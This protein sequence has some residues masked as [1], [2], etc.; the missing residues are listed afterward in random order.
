MRSRKIWAIVFLAFIVRFVNVSNYPAGFTADEANQ[1]YSAYSILM[2][3]RDEW[4]EPFPITPRSFGDYKAPL[5]TYLTIPSV[6]VF[7]LSEFAVRFPAVIL[8]TLTVPVVYFLCLELFKDKKIAVLSSFLLAISPW[9]IALSR[10]AFEANLPTLLTPLGVLFFLKAKKQK[11]YMLAAALS[12]GLGLFS[13]HS[14]RLLF[15]LIMAFLYLFFKPAIAKYKMPLFLL[16]FF[17]SVALY[18]MFAGASSRIA[19]VSILGESSWKAVSEARYHAVVMG[20]PDFVARIFNNKLTYIVGLFTKNYLSYFSTQ[21]LFTEGAGEATYGMAPG[22]GLLYTLELLFLLSFL[23]YIVVNKLYKS[24]AIGLIVVFLLIAPIPAAFSTGPGM[25]ANRAAVMMPWIQ[26]L[27]AIGI[28]AALKFFRNK[29]ALPVI[30][31]YFVVSFVFF[32]EKYFVDAPRQNSRFM[33]YGWRQ[34]SVYLNKMEG[35]FDRIVVSKSFS[36]PQ[37]FVAFYMRVAPEFFQDESSDWLRYEKEGLKFVDQLGE[38][39][40]GKFVFRR[41]N[42]GSDMK[43]PAMLLVG[44]PEDFPGIVPDYVI[45]YPDGEKAIYFVATSEAYAKKI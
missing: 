33:G 41:I 22:I 6:A 28:A 25:A 29:Y 43:I 30:L 23:V 11:A 44:K 26:I 21:F 1:G 12:F 40:L 18:T 34:A 20:M 8:G 3:G 27:S 4:G 24:P 42:P 9:H 19:D 5:Y 13:Y 2:T 31:V 36:E 14:F 45:N 39:H 10:G 16:A 15:P 32:L 37:M 17:V 35:S 7:G 38:Y